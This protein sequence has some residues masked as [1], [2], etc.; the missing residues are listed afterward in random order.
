MRAGG[1]SDQPVCPS[2]GGH[3][4]AVDA[5]R[6]EGEQDA[7]LAQQ[8][9]IARWHRRQQHRRHRAE[10]Q[11]QTQQPSAGR[12]ALLHPGSPRLGVAQR[13]AGT[14]GPALG[15]H[16][17]RHRLQP[18]QVEVKHHE[19]RQLRRRRDGRRQL[20]RMLLHHKRA[21]RAP[22]E[23]Q[24]GNAVQVRVVPV[25]PA[26]V[27]LGDHVFIDSRLTGRQCREDIV[28]QRR[29]VKAVGVKTSGGQTR[30]VALALQPAA[31]ASRIRDRRQVVAQPDSQSV[32]RLHP[33]CGT[34]QP[35]VEPVCECANA[36]GA[37]VPHHAEGQVQGEGGGASNGAQDDGGH[38]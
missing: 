1:A 38:Q 11:P 18:A 12:H 9:H 21:G 15:R 34:G 14:H 17:L 8:P 13:L 37:E 7:V 5:A 10:D 31:Q 20:P 24:R 36:P 25:R 22:P 26:L 19:H 4:A 3:N 35:S 6:R 29:G 30:G 2:S 23:L 27:L 16:R 33:D 28:G 32:T